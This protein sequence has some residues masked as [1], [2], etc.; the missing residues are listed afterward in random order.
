MRKVAA[1]GG[2]EG[3]AKALLGTYQ[4]G[5]STGVQYFSLCR[6]GLDGS[7]RLTVTK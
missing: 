4:E 3:K 2:G 6:L 7:K 1:I 5:F